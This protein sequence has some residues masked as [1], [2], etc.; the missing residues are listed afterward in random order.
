MKYVRLFSP[1]FIYW[2]SDRCA[3]LNICLCQLFDLIREFHFRFMFLICRENKYYDSGKM[4]PRDVNK[5]GYR[6]VCLHKL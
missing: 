4:R 3:M 1:I 2:S 6:N 5:N